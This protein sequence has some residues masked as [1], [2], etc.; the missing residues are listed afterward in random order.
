MTIDDLIDIFRMG[1]SFLSSTQIL[2]MPI[3]FW[4]ILVAIFGII[5]SFIKG[6]KNN[7]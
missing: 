4:F 5:G 1:F 6:T 7:D 3:I 2:G